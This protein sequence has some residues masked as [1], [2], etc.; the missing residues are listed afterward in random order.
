MLPVKT[1]LCGFR[2]HTLREIIEVSTELVYQQHIIQWSQCLYH[3][4]TLMGQEQEG[5]KRS[6][7]LFT[8]YFARMIWTSPYQNV[9]VTCPM[10]DTKPKMSSLWKWDD[11]WLFG[12]D[13]SLGTTYASQLDLRLLHAGHC[14]GPSIYQICKE[15]Q[16]WRGSR[17]NS[18]WAVNVGS[19]KTSL[20]RQ[21]RQSWERDFLFKAGVCT[22]VTHL[23]LF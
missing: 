19:Q 5:K 23:E 22:F 14:W 18:I 15:A 21:Q 10:K 11:W 8:Y 20:H 12:L 2:K 1:H 7:V 17:S 6:A 16:W 4:K 3:R 13:V 9:T